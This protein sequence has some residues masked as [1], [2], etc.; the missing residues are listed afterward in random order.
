MDIGLSPV[1]S[2]AK[3]VTFDPV[4][5]PEELVARWQTIIDTMAALVGVPAGL[6]M[7]LTR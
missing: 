1:S 4:E 2:A 3:A 5:V 6:I 7:R